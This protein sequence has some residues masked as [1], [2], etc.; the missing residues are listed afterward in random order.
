MF[1]ARGKQSAE[2]RSGGYQRRDQEQ[3]A[4]YSC[5][6]IFFSRACSSLAPGFHAH[7]GG[8]QLVDEPV[9]SV[10]SA[11]MLYFRFSFSPHSLCQTTLLFFTL[12]LR[13]WVPVHRCMPPSTPISSGLRHPFSEHFFFPASSCTYVFPLTNTP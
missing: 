8:G 2:G 12:S 9:S 7:C 11:P 1:A 4:W 10:C 6:R 13:L 5:L 3:R